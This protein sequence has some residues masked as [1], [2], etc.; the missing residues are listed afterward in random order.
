MIRSWWIRALLAWLG[1][2]AGVRGENTLIGAGATFPAPLYEKWFATFAK[3]VPGTSIQYRAVG[4]IAGIEAL[5]KGAADFAGSDIPLGEARAPGLPGK[6]RQIPTV[7]GGIVPIYNLAGIVAD[8]RFTPET[9]ADIYLGRIKRWNDPALKAANRGLTLPARDIVVV[10]RSDRSGTTF[11]FTN[12]LS[13]VSQQWKS[14]AGCGDTVTWPVG[15]SGEG[16]GGVSKIVAGTPGAIGYVEF[17]YALEHQ[18][19]YGAVQNSSGHFLQADLAS[20]QA[21]AT[22]FANS[23]PDDFGIAITN[24]PGRGSYPIASFTYLFIRDQSEN[25][26]KQ[27]AML[28]F[29][30]WMLTLGQ[31]QAAALGYAALPS[32]L[33]KRVLEELQ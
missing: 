25:L 13:K 11:I 9:L 5:T 17:I 31:G 20:L 3:R 27:G 21:A 16:N 7:V 24:A 32:E 29:L 6:F 23:I 18:L 33:A 26:T 2:A 8:I 30:R 19:D 15:V 28:G 10:H 12:Y 22:D 4:S 14:F 1:V